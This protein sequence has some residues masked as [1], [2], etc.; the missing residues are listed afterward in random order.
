MHKDHI[1]QWSARKIAATRPRLVCVAGSEVVMADELGSTVADRALAIVTALSAE[2]VVLQ[3][4]LDIVERLAA[5]RGLF[6][7]DAVDSYT[8][9][10]EETA[11]ITVQRRG[12]ID[13]VFG[14]MKA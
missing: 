11:A 5:Q 10:P 12:F 14:A 9:S 6:T 2:V 4:R 8:P 1:R 7:P 13:R 3:R